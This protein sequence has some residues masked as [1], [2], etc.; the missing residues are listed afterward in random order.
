M[1]VQFSINYNTQNFA[2][3]HQMYHI[4]TNEKGVRYIGVRIGIIET[5]YFCF[6]SVA[7]YDHSPLC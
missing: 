1:I 2:G 5:D 6:V 7:V 3:I 4:R